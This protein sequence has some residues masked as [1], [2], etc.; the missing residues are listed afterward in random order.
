MTDPL[1]PELRLAHD[2]IDRF[3]EQAAVE[4]AHMHH[5][6]ALLLQHLGHLFGRLGL[7]KVR[8]QIEFEQP[9]ERALAA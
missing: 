1:V 2:P 3:F 8:L 5:M 9:L 6:E 7:L 4:A